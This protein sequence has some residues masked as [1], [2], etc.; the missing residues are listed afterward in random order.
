MAF[1]C[2]ALVAGC[3]PTAPDETPVASVPSTPAKPASASYKPGEQVVVP[4]F[5]EEPLPDTAEGLVAEWKKLTGDP[6]MNHIMMLRPVQ[7]AG[8]LA[9]KGDHALDPILDVLADP[10]SDPRQKVLVVQSLSPHITP[11]YLPRLTELLKSSED[12]TVR[13]CATMLVAQLKGGEETAL[14]AGLKDDPDR[15]VRLSAIVGLTRRG[16][17]Q[18]RQALRDWYATP[19]ATHDEKTQIIAT[20]LQDPVHDD[21][22][23]LGNA[24]FDP[25]TDSYQ[26]NN[27]VLLLGRQG[28]EAELKIL[29]AGLGEVTDP[30][31]K[32]MVQAAANAIRARITAG[33]ASTPSTEAQA[34]AEAASAAPQS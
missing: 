30:V 4:S 20:L 12:D 17:A 34:P 22:A 2:S 25:T 24:A 29:E 18:S 13:A 31:V 33:A 19:E 3:I 27:L 32:N 11:A 26:Q 1:L 6:A 23:L 15:R 10:A 8:A 21:F 5:Q 9:K 7:L 28:G 16:D 14:L